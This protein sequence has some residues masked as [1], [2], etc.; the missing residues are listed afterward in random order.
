M[1]CEMPGPWWWGDLLTT[2][3]LFYRRVILAEAEE[4]QRSPGAGWLIALVTCFLFDLQKAF[5]LYGSQN[6]RK[7]FINVFQS[8]LLCLGSNI[9]VSSVTE[10]LY[11][12]MIKGTPS[13]KH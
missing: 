12:P 11:T 8:L 13:I 7:E 4:H 10:E 1:T 6:N 5:H 3:C 2:W 9:S